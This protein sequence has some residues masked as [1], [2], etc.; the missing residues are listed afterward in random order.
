[1]VSLLAI[2][3]WATTTIICKTLSGTKICNKVVLKRNREKSCAEQNLDDYFW[4][5]S[6]WII[7]FKFC[8]SIN[9][10]FAMFTCLVVL[11]YCATAKTT[12]TSKICSLA[13][14]FQPGLCYYHNVQSCLEIFDSLG[15]LFQL[16]QG[17]VL[18]NWFWATP[19]RPAPRLRKH[20]QLMLPFVRLLGFLRKKIFEFDNTPTDTQW[21][22]PTWRDYISNRGFPLLLWY[23]VTWAGPFI[24]GSKLFEIS[25][26]FFRGPQN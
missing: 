7:L 23:Q 26:N 18:T 12:T 22:M 15:S 4:K 14:T 5:L 2:L 16:G 13:L 25:L 10:E 1:M 20:Q 17:E 8:K 9:A 3:K 24:V 6:S 19:T 21:A 11:F